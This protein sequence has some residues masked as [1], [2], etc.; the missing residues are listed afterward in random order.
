ML[1]SRDLFSKEQKGRHKGT[2]GPG[3]LVYN[4]EQIFKESKIRRKM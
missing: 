3:D 1:I 4:D 2:S